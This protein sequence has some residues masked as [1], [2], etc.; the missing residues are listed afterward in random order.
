MAGESAFVTP[1]QWAACED[2]RGVPPRP[3]NRIELYVGLDAAPKHDSTA[4]VSAYWSDGLLRLGPYRIW[5]SSFL[6]PLSFP[7]VE[8]YVRTLHLTF[9]VRWILADPFQMASM[10]AGLKSEG[11][12]IEEFPQ[13]SGNL[14]RATQALFDMVQRRQLRVYSAPDLREHVVEN[15]VAVESAR[16]L[17]LEKIRSAKKI[18]GAVALSMAIVAALEAPRPSIGDS[19][20]ILV[21]GRRATAEARL[22]EVAGPAGVYTSWEERSARAEAARS[23]GPGGAGRSGLVI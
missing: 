16:G 2:P 21:G 8:A 11:V 13:T 14:T 19:S 18:D 17:K 12:A 1:E 23:Q 20:L 10:I 22:L 9:T 7:D 5:R 4:V 3:D 15:A 6:R